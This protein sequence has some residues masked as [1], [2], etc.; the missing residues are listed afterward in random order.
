MHQILESMAGHLRPSPDGWPTSVVGF[1]ARTMVTRLELAETLAMEERKRVNLE[2]QGAPIRDRV[3]QAVIVEQLASAVR[4]M[5]AEVA[6]HAVVSTYDPAG[7]F[8]PGETVVWSGHLSRAEAQRALPLWAESLRDV[9]S[10]R[11]EY[12]SVKVNRMKRDG[13][14][15]PS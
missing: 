14:Q 8:R 4:N 3:E 15:G 9:G 1:S 7:N 11:V 13:W 10:L 6:A 2:E 5:S 12:R